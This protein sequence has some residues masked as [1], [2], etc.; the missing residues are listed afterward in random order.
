MEGF[1]S[2]LS[3]FLLKFCSYNYIFNGRV[4]HFLFVKRSPATVEALVERALQHLGYELVD[5][6]RASRGRLIRVFIDQPGGAITVDDCATVSHH[7]S[8]LFA[9]E[10]VDYDRLEVS[11]PGLDRPLK[12][13]ADFQRFVGAQARIRLRHPLQG[14]SN[15]IATLK[16]AEGTKIRVDL[17]G[18]ELELDVADIERARLVPRF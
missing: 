10:G 16:A 3:V 11:S 6:E 1:S 4:A 9:V 8:R 15:F 5:L 18:A 13:V 17:E 7:L 2:T 14:R 12:R